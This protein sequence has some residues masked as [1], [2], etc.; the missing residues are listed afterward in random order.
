MTSDSQRLSS[1]GV[2]RALRSIPDRRTDG[3]W[4]EV[5]G[6]GS[7]TVSQYEPS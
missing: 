7:L 3:Y 1:N 6:S 5:S 4:W 2:R